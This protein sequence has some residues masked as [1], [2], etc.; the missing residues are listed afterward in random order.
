MS[1]FLNE[2]DMA[3][4]N[5]VKAIRPEPTRTVGIAGRGVVIS[6]K[7]ETGVGWDLHRLA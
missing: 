5:T 4:I 6:S 1:L 3:A 7:K 2:M